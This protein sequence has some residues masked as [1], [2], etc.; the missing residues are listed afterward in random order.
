MAV[1][2]IVSYDITDSKAYEPYVPGVVPLI[3]KHGGEIVVGEFAA[4]P[5]EGEPHGVYVVLR[6]PSEQAARTWYSD[7][8][9]E[10]LKKIRL[11][12]CRNNNMVIA[13]SAGE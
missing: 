12:A 1:Y 3:K 6:F 13:K 7:P 8:D 2:I 10:P 9:Y 4:K 5:L 11:T